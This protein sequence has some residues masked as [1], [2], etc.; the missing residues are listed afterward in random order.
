MKKYIKRNQ[1]LITALAVMIAVAGYLSFREKRSVDKNASMTAEVLDDDSYVLDLSEE[2]LSYMGYGEETAETSGEVAQNADVTESYVAAAEFAESE[3]ADLT[4][5]DMIPGEAVF[6]NGTA[7]TTLSGAKLL[8]EQT[9]AKNK[10]TL[11]EIINN[12]SIEE[13]AKTE[14]VNA[15][16]ASTKTAEKEMA[17]EILLEAKGFKGA[18]VSVTDDSADVCIVAE[19]LDD[20]KRAQIEDIVARKTNV[21][22]EKIV[23]TNIW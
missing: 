18:V 16:V 14:A 13:A 6:T 19:S 21:E 1:I 12:Q 5:E 22:P 3:T 8:K 17:A 15:M 10:E 7:I 23:I 20:A 4:E 11:L 9:R 2:E